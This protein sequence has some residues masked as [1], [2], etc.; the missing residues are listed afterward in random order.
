MISAMETDMPADHRPLATVMEAAKYLNLSR[1]AV[2]LLLDT[3]R[4]RYCRLP[5]SGN[6]RKHRRIPWAEIER[7]VQDSLTAAQ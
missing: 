2:Y 3:G 1:S 6:V 5:G 7:F 4:I